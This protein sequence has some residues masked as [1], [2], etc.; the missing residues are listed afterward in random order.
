[1]IKYE[2]LG[3]I[4]HMCQTTKEGVN[5]DEQAP[6]C[7]CGCGQHV[8]WSKYAKRWNKYVNV[9][10][11]RRLNILRGDAPLCAC[12]CG[13][14]VTWNKHD[15]RWN[16]Y[17]NGGHAKRKPDHVLENPPLCACGCGDPVKMSRDYGWNEFLRGHCNRGGKLSEEHKKKLSEAHKGLTVWNKGT[18]GVCVAWNKGMGKGRLREPYPQNWT[19]ELK[20]RIRERDGRLCQLCGKNEEENGQRLSCHHINSEKSDLAFYN[21]VTLCRRCHTRTTAHPK[22]WQAFFEGSQYLHT[23]EVA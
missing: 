4:S 8:S 6:L 21:L 17:V 13:E 2:L 12:G 9:G 5:M 20:E 3:C 18:K 15:K 23:L 16:T 19:V 11:S 14:H 1:V 10:H 7:K 22:L